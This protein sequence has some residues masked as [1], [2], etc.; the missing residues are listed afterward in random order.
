MKNAV[1]RPRSG[2]GGPVTVRHDPYDEH[3]PPRPGSLCSW[4]DFLRH[5]PEGRQAAS[6]KEPW[7]AL[8]EA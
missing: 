6:P 7:A 2:E 8:P 5:C 4:C 1:P 3:F